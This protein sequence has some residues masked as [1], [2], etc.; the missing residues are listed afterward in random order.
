MPTLSD[1][2]TPA[3]DYVA[4]DRPAPDE[5]VECGQPEHAHHASTYMEQASMQDQFLR[6]R[7]TV[8][9]RQQ[10]SGDVTVREAAD[11]RIEA[12][13]KHLAAT[14]ALRIEYFGE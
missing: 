2:P 10:E 3:H 9:R 1:D 7:L 6:D 8:I 11:A 12:M 14:R 5:C 4:P 13:E